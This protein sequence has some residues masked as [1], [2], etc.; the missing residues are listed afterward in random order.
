MLALLL[1]AQLSAQMPPSPQL[2]LFRSPLQSRAAGVIGA[3]PAKA[4]DATPGRMEVSLAQPAALYRQ[5]DRPAKG[6]KKWADYPDGRLC[7]V[8]DAR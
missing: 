1:A 4:C 6:L 2:Q 7:A 8:E 3:L 5:G